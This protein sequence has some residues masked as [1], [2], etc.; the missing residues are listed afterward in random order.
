MTNGFGAIMHRMNYI[1]RWG[2]MRNARTE[3]LSEHT[4]S[5]AYI[6][7][8]LACMANARF[9][10]RVDINKLTCAALYHDAPE[11]L[12][13][14]LPTPVKY[15]NERMRAEYKQVEQQ[16]QRQLVSMLP[17]DIA[18][19]MAGALTGE[20]LTERERA[21]LKAADKLSALIKCIEEEAAGNTEFASAKQATIDT[22]NTDPL[23]ETVCF[24]EEFIP[25]Y[26][27]TLDELMRL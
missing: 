16:A 8:L 3:S 14:D 20:E 12:T 13:G 4:L 23:P 25:A 21:I 15:G 2:L 5:T 26:S 9:G 27:L 19:L 6:A 7:H 10:A 22:L 1:N 17:A 11:I 18:P 24:L